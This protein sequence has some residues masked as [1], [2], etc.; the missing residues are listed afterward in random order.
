MAE[1]TRAVL[2]RKKK[3][4]WMFTLQQMPST[5]APTDNNTG[6][7]NQALHIA[8]FQIIQSDI[9][10][11]FVIGKSKTFEPSPAVGAK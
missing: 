6:N 8:K 7:D 2:Q 3:N 1:T 4:I 11:K 5:E 9:Y 10:L